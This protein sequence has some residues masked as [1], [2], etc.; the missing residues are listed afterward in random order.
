VQKI[1]RDE[2]NKESD[3]WLLQKPA[4]KNTIPAQKTIIEY[5]Q[6]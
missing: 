6:K 4:Q 1:V 5:T 3:P 2:V